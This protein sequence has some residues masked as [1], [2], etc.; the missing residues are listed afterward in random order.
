ML[1]TKLADRPLA[2]FVFSLDLCLVVFWLSLYISLCTHRS[3]LASTPIVHVAG[4]SVVVIYFACR[5]IFEIVNYT[6]LG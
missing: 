4:L 6:H 2:L 5:E 1:D 3:L